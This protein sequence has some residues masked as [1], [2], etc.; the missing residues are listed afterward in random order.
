MPFIILSTNLCNVYVEDVIPEK[1]VFQQHYNG[2]TRMLFN[3]NLTPYLIE[4]GVIALTDQEELNA[5]PTSTGKAAFLLPKVTSALMTGKTESFYKILEIMKCY[6]NHDAQQ[7]SDTIAS[8]IPGPRRGKY[9]Q[10]FRFCGTPSH[11]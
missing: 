7:L 10:I 8:K 11:C 4:E 9:V 3:T 1:E 2:L 5:I 6:G